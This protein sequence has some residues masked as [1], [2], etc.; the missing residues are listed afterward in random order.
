[1]VK[2]CL[3]C[4][5]VMMAFYDV[6]WNVLATQVSEKHMLAKEVA[7]INSELLMH[8]DVNAVTAKKIPQAEGT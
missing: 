4:E 3:C 7:E 2:L 5:L 6:C 8:V 1:M